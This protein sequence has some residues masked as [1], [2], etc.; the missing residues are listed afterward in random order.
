MGTTTGSSPSNSV[1]LQGILDAV[2]EGQMNFLTDKEYH[3]LLVLAESGLRYAV[4][5]ERKIFE[6]LQRVRSELS[7]VREAVEQHGGRVALIPVTEDIS[8]S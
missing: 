8:S 2:I 5:A 4:D 3:A 7:D 6:T 1:D